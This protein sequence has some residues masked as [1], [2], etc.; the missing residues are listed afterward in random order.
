LVGTAGAP[1]DLGG[2]QLADEDAVRLTFA[3]GTTLRPG[4]AVVVV[5]FDP[6]DEITAALFRDAFGVDASVELVGPYAGGLNTD[7]AVVQLL[8]PASV[9]V[10]DPG[11]VLVDRVAYGTSAPWP[12]AAAGPGRALVR[13]STAALG[14]LAQSWSALPP[15]PGT[16]HFALPG[17]LDFDG[18]IDTPDVDGFA[19]VLADSSAYVAAY[20]VPATMVADVDGN[21][22][23]DFDDID[24]F[25]MLL[26]GATVASTPHVD[27]RSIRVRA[28]ASAAPARRGNRV[29][30]RA[31]DRHRPHVRVP[32]LLRLSAG[33]NPT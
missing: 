8:Q 7:G 13:A 2:W 12:T 29:A 4:T 14:Y 3:P 30:V 6:N 23:V 16:A 5:D 33:R 9:A 32:P 18:V 10:V 27:T 19:Q 17:D 26:A 22:A 25:V 24:D 31:A 11:M 21:G 20:G 1:I 28:V 15:T